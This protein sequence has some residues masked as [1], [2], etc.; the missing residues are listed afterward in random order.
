MKPAA[1][2]QP[3]KHVPTHAMADSL[4]CAPPGANSEEGREQ[5]KTEMR[6][7]SEMPVMPRS[8][9]GLSAFSVVTTMNRNSIGPS[10]W[11][12]KTTDQR[13]RAASPTAPPV[14]NLP[15]NVPANRTPKPSRRTSGLTETSRNTSEQSLLRSGQQSPMPPMPSINKQDKRPALSLLHT[16]SR[17]DLGVRP[18]GSSQMLRPSMP[19]QWQTETEQRLSYIP[20]EVDAIPE[21]QASVEDVRQATISPVQASAS[22]TKDQRYASRSPISWNERPQQDSQTFLRGEDHDKSMNSPPKD[23]TPRLT[24]QS[25]PVQSM[26]PSEREPLRNTQHVSKLPQPVGNGRLQKQQPS[27]ERQYSREP[28]PQQQHESEQQ[29]IFA[30]TPQRHRQ[31]APRQEFESEARLAGSASPRYQLQSMLVQAM[32]KAEG[33]SYYQNEDHHDS[34]Y[35]A[36]EEERRQFRNNDDGEAYQSSAMQKY[37]QGSQQPYSPDRSHEGRRQ[38]LSRPV[39]GRALSFCPREGSTLTH[40]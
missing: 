2:A 16:G 29:D 23:K 28:V 21:G 33:N 34:G 18:S 20:G 24:R 9:S 6:R 26:Y 17:N 22:P 7:R 4:A 12:N 15:A 40:P 25:L 30:P 10:G 32:Y 31:P 1:P 35:F 3:Y 14:P 19:G 13:S 11:T 8:T 5:I 38:M 36:S 37:G 39:S 27:P